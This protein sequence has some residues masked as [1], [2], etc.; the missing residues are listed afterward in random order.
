MWDS[1]DYDDIYD[2]ITYEESNQDSS[3]I[4]SDNSSRKPCR[5]TTRKQLTKKT[6]NQ[7][8]PKRKSVQTSDSRV[9][10]L[11]NEVALDQSKEKRVHR[12]PHPRFYEEELPISVLSESS[13]S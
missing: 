6:K 2:E 8:N 9:D 1:Y 10:R 4:S 13:H 7:K 3:D 12:K 11:R 5:K